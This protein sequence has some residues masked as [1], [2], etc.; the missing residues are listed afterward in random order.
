MKKLGFPSKI[1]HFPSE[2]AVEEVLHRHGE[3]LQHEPHGAPSRIEDG[4]LEVRHRVVRRHAE[5]RDPTGGH[6]ADGV[7][8][9]EANEEGIYDRLYISN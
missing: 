4:H 3:E 9:P 2:I 6:L 8:V 5:G 7:P 1:G